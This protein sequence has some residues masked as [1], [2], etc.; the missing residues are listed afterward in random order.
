[1]PSLQEFL[2]RTPPCL[3][4]TYFD[5]ANK[6]LP[7]NIAWDAP[8]KLLLKQLLAGVDGL[9]DAARQHVMNDA[10]RLGAMADEAGQTAIFGVINAPTIDMLERL[11]NGHARAVW[12]WIHDRHRFEH[13]EQIRYADTKRFGR[14]WDSFVGQKRVVV[15]RDD[16]SLRGFEEAV[17]ATFRTNNVK[18][19]ICDRVRTTLDQPDARLVQVAI[20]REGRSGDRRAFVEGELE[21]LPDRPV[22]EA[23]LT[24]EQATG[25]I[26]VVANDRETRRVFAG[27]FAKHLL[28]SAF[29]GERL[30]LRQYRLD[31]L[32]G[33]TA[34]SSE[35]ADNIES[36]RLSLLRLR[37][38]DTDAE[39]ITLECMG[40]RESSI[41]DMAASRFGEHDPLSEGYRVTQARLVIRFKALP[42]VR[43]NRTLPVT[44]S[45]PNGCNLKD[46]TR[47]E[48]VIGQ[49]YLR[50][51]GLLTDV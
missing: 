1:M 13:A 46:R 14:M 45:I 50:R 20:Y 6:H 18:I 38:L 3:L 41:W 32:R 7:A 9:D 33:P 30:P 4:Q 34:F 29:T 24:Y 2:Q 8:P 42:G 28:H 11:E 39:R 48:Q 17:R 15:A 19:E 10:D 31:H 25:V 23:A 51:W 5:G 43:G 36:V 44:I 35:A 21:R 37:P 40:R 16:D 22:I 12:M 26:E 47:R 49:K 27:L